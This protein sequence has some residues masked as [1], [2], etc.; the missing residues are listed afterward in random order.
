MEN[1]EENPYYLP[2]L[3]FNEMLAS[4]TCIFTSSFLF[5]SRHFLFNAIIMAEH[6]LA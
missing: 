1:V 6:S 3:L 2:S 4:Q 5:K